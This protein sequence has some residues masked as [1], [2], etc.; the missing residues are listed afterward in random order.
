MVDFLFASGVLCVPL[1]RRS[2]SLTVLPVDP[3]A[4]PPAPLINPKFC[5]TATVSPALIDVCAS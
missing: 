5:D 4:A 2:P 3:P 1:A